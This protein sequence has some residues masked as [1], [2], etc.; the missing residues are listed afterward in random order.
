MYILLTAVL[1]VFLCFAV[2]YPL[3]WFATTSP[4]LYT[5]ILFFLAV[6]AAVFF[7][8]RI[9]LK[10]Y[11]RCSSS[12]Q[13]KRLLIRTLLSLGILLIIMIT[14]S[15]SVIFVFMEKRLTAL[16]VFAAGIFL[17]AVIRRLKGRFPD[18]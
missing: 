1:S 13:K 14:L 16:I 5:R 17:S 12:E 15:I 9:F 4:H 8:V 3:W 6:S 7:I 2:V 11:K 10:R 18:V